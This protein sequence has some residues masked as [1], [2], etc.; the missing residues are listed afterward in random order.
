MIALVAGGTGFIG[1][2]LVRTLA[3]RGVRVRVL[4]R[5]KRRAKSFD[6]NIEIVYGDI[7]DVDSLEEC[8]RGADLVFSAF[9]VLGQWRIPESTYRKVNR[10]GVRNLLESCLSASIRQFIHVS[11]A[12]VLGPLPRGVVA[13]ESFAFRPSNAYEESKCEAEKEIVAFGEKHG[14][15]YTII[16]PEFVYGPGDTH[17][18]GLFKAIK[19][20]RFLLLGDGTSLLHPTYIDDLV[21]GIDLCINNPAAIDQAYLIIGER[22]LTV[23]DLALTIAAEL[24]VGLPKVKVPLFLAYAAA[25]VLELGGKI[26]GFEPPLTRS[27]LKFFTQNRSFSFEKA[28]S[29]IGYIPQISFSEGV[30]RTVSWY[31]EHRCL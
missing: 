31:R 16:R 21:H 14:L 6:H 19:E 11:S 8:T 26:A 2:H 15:P 30:K 25:G 5:K 7:L 22:A 4:S 10:V 18:L 29:H 27:R 23:R 28:R 9:G 20:R 12:G 17:V 24:N 3:S 13:D 1:G